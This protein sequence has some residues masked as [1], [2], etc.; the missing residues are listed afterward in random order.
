MGEQPSLGAGMLGV[1]DP[2]L[3]EGFKIFPR[4]LWDLS[5]DVPTAVPLSAFPA[6]T[7]RIPGSPLPGRLWRRR[8]VSHWERE[9]EEG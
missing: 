3:L 7:Q 1:C 4:R 6:L 5:T 9:R 8:L 2:E